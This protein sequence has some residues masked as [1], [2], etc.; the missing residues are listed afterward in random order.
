VDPA[1]VASNAAVWDFE[2][3][4]AQLASL[5]GIEARDGPRRFCWDPTGVA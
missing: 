4:A 5:D 2:L 3:N 1:R